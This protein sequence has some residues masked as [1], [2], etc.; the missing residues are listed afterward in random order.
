[1]MADPFTNRQ[2]FL[3]QLAAFAQ[4][5]PSKVNPQVMV[6]NMLNSGQMTQDQYNYCRMLANR[7][8]G[9]NY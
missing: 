7:I 1:M 5:L 9:K 2:L 3:Q 6:Q 4:Q 8:T